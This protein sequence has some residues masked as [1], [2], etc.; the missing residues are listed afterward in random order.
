M[1]VPFNRFE[2][3]LTRIMAL[4]DRTWKIVLAFDLFILLLAATIMLVTG[5]VSVP[6]LLL[7]LGI[8][9]LIGYLLARILFTYNRI[10]RDT[11][12]EL[13]K[14]ATELAQRNADL[15]AFSMT[16]AHDLKTPI[17]NI[18]GYTY[19]L[20]EGEEIDTFARLDAAEQIQASAEKMSR[21]IDDLLFLARIGIRD[22]QLQPVEMGAIVENSLNRLAPMIEENR[23]TVSLPAE[24]PPAKGHAGWLEEVWVNYISNAIKYGG[25]PP[26]ITLG[27]TRD[28]DK[29]RFWVHDNGSGILPGDLE[30]LFKEFSRLDRTQADGHGLG[31]AIVRRII[32]KLEGEVGVDS[33]PGEGST[34][35]FTLPGS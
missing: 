3:L 12:A 2:F 33:Q 23:A 9:T 4:L 16:V 17:N 34:F 11:L 13:K 28:G 1:G 21:I 8:S 22:V 24:W 25:E 32:L 19:L 14:V 5:P 15:E 18:F 30:V 6:V 20:R 29:A 10:N 31:L 26:S 35:F 27:G 7:L